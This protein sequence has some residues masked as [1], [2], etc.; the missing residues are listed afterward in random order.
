MTRVS[1]ESARR[2]VLVWLLL[3]AALH[4]AANAQMTAAPTFTTECAVAAGR[5]LVPVHLNGTGPHTFVL[6]LALKRPVLHGATA[7]TL[8]LTPGKLDPLPEGEATQEGAPETITRVALF[9]AG[10]LP[11]QSETCG[12]LDLTPL[13]VQLGMHVAGLLPAHQP[14]YEVTISFDPPSVIWMPLEYAQLLEPGTDTVEMMLNEDGMPGVRVRVNGRQERLCLLDLGLN[15]T[16]A[17]TKGQLEEM[18]AVSAS[19][20]LLRL[21][22]PGGAES[23]QV[24]LGAIA[25]GDAVAARPVCEVAPA[26]RGD[27]LGAGFVRQFPV[28]LNYEH[29]LA[30][31]GTNEDEGKQEAPLV[32]CGVLPVSYDSGFWRLAVVEGSPAYMAGV[33][34]GDMLF[35]ANGISL[36]A[37]SHNDLCKLLTMK[38]GMRI[39]LLIGRDGT[40]R[41]VETVAA[42][43]L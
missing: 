17:F 43:M 41:V 29:G 10:T 31:F 39:R 3:A 27:R 22:M 5:L 30:R 4:S 19:T 42:E 12:V 20:P 13:S 21:L 33:L 14:G 36:R 8:G 37:I 34:P 28:T 16:A 24:R 40:Q 32:G 7:A 26:G 35:G 2:G 9:Q 25:V 18:D 38:E 6:D 23:E 15:A 1:E 11:P